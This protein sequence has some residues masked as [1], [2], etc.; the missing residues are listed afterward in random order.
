MKVVVAI[1]SLK[2]SLSSLDAGNAIR[3]GILWADPEAEV[4]V[5][6]M[7]DGG[8]GTTEALV[9][10]LGGEL[11][12]VRVTGPY[13]DPTE[14]VY[15]L[16]KQ[17]NMAVMEMA[18]AAGITLSAR[19]EPLCAT[20]FGVGEMIR[21]ALEQG[22]RRFIIGIGGSATNDGGI[23]MLSALGWRF[24][25]ARGEECPPVAAGLDRIAQIDAGGV[26]PELAECRFQI[27]CDV[28]NPLC[29]ENGCTYVFGPQKGVATE[30]EKQ[31]LDRAMGHYA[32][33][34]AETFG[35][36]NRTVPGVGAAGGL[37][38]AFLSFLKGKLQPGIEIVLSALELEQAVHNADLVITGEGCLDGQTAF[39]KAP[40]GVAACAKKYGV[41]VVALAGSVKPEARVCNQHGIDA[42]FPILPGVMTLEQAMQ[43]E[44][45]KSNLSRTAE[46]L[47]RFAKCFYSV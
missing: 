4:A 23:G 16:L 46:Q 43:P 20:T 18:S 6:P 28:T 35:T 21:D 36:D 30:E 13:G 33:V 2:G 37:G 3:R 9:D 14:A 19:R 26:R 32:D 31:A 34:V 39:G 10:A 15:G 1:D 45:A 17:Q 29:G 44:E 22:C 47:M 7:A 42:Y 24:L 25:D 5:K 12:T 27:A 41:P 8:E 11:R 38:F 40:A